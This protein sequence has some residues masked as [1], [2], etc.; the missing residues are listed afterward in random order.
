SKAPAHIPDLAAH[1][2]QS[3]V[4]EAEREYLSKI[5]VRT[6]L[7]VPM[8]RNDELIG[9][10]SLGR[11]RGEP[12]TENEIELLMDFPAETAIALEIIRREREL[13]ELQIE[14]ARANRIATMEQLSSSIAH[15]VVQ[16]IASARH[17]ARAAQ[18]FLAMTPPDLGEVS[19]ALACVVA[20]AD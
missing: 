3:S 1:L 11:W 17:N 16:P 20:D 7:I 6:T 14:L 5:D 4:G 2:E 15:E 18:N 19:D 13:R 12:F 10:L 9:S 8:L